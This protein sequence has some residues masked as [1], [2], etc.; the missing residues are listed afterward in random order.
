MAAVICVVGL[1]Y[2]YDKDTTDDSDHIMA[3]YKDESK[4]ED[5]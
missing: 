2:S 3:I 4:E 1:S 5:T